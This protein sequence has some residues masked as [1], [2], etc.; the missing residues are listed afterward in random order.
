MNR[1]LVSDFKNQTPNVKKNINRTHSALLDELDDLEL[2]IKRCDF[3]TEFAK[4]ITTTT[5]IK[6]IKDLIILFDYFK[7][8]DT[9]NINHEDRNHLLNIVKKV[10]KRIKLHLYQLKILVP[11]EVPNNIEYFGMIIKISLTILLK[12]NKY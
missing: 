2:T 3:D 1:C 12:V 9:L 7:N 10:N 4:L 6:I 5:R 11:K 8:K